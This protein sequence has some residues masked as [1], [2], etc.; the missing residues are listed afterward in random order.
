MLTEEPNEIVREGDVADRGGRLRL[1]ESASGRP[2]P[3]D[4]TATWRLP[5][6]SAFSVTR[7]PQRHWIAITLSPAPS[8]LGIVRWASS[9]RADPR[10]PAEAASSCRSAWAATR[11]RRDGSDPPGC[12]DMR[13]VTGRLSS[14][15]P[16]RLPARTEPRRR[17]HGE[18]RGDSPGRFAPGRGRQS[19]LPT[20]GGE[21]C[22][23]DAGLPS[24]QSPVLA[25]CLATEDRA[26]RCSPGVPCR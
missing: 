10:G 15:P 24:G 26:A 19:S 7:P 22:R 21:L 9:R 4:M 1:R 3:P 5:L 13:L 6:L 18:G 25:E 11:P 12:E 17:R 8:R 14:S 20:R 23:G 16:T 2:L